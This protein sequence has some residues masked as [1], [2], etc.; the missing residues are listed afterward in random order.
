LIVAKHV[1]SESLPGV[2]VSVRPSLVIDANQ[3]QNRI[4]RNRGEGVRRHTMDLAVLVNGN[5]GDP[6]CETPHCLA[7]IVSGKAHTETSGLCLAAVF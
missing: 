6:G 7:E 5:D 2:Q 4:E 1:H 3:N